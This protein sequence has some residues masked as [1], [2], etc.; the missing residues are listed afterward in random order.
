MY[1]YVQ[2]LLSIISYFFVTYTYH[3]CTALSIHTK[4]YGIAAEYTIPLQEP[5]GHKICCGGH[6]PEVHQI[7]LVLTSCTDNASLPM[8][9]A[10]TLDPSCGC[11]PAAAAA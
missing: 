8:Q 1:M 6:L 11:C 7:K 3:R 2:T 5:Q 4:K 9:L 10:K